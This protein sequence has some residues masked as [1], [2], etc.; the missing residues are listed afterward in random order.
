MNARNPLLWTCIIATGST[1]AHADIFTWLNGSGVWENPAMWNGPV[2]QYPDSILDTA[3]ISGNLTSATLNQNLALGTLNVLNGASVYSNGNS[4]FVNADT[5]LIG[6]GSALSVTPSPSLRDFDT[7]TLT[8]SQAILAMYGGLAQFDE[9]LIINNNGGVLGVGTIEMNSTTGHLVLN[10]GALWAT[11]GSGPSDTFLITRTDSSTSKLDWTSPD[12][13]IIVWDG[14][15]MINELPY[16]GSLGG[17]IQVSNYDDGETTF[18]SINGFIAAA[19]SELVFSGDNP[20]TPNRLVAPFIDSYGEV[21]S[22]GGKGII[23]SPIVALRGNIELASSTNLTIDAPLLIFNSID[24]NDDGS[25]NIVQFTANPEGTINFTGGASSIVMGA[26]SRFDLD[27]TGANTV[28]IADGSSVWLEAEYLDFG[29][30]S[31]F[32]GTLNIDGSLHLEPVNGNNFLSNNGEINLDSGQITG[33]GIFNTGLVRGTGSISGYTVNN[34][35]IIADAG[36]LQFGTVVMDGNSGTGILRAQ[37][38][39]LVMN[40][41]ANGSDQ[42]FTGQILVGNGIGVR[43]VLNAN[44]NLWVRDTNGQRGSIELNS[45]FVVLNDFG[46]NADM[47]VDGVS[48]LRVTGNNAEDRITFGSGSITTINGTLEAD[49]NTW[50][51]PGAQVNGSGTIDIVSTNKGI[52]FQDGATLG[53]V[54]LISSGAISLLDFFEAHASVHELTM[55]PTASLNMSMW[56]SGLQDEIITDLLTVQDHAILDGDLV[57]TNYPETDLPSGRTVTILEAASIEGGFDS[58]DFS[59]LGPN[60]RAFVTITETTVEVFVTCFA[61]LNADGQLN[62]FDASEFLTRYGQQDPLADLNADGQ[63]NFF[64]VAAFLS[65][66]DLGC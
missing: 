41:Q 26:G 18:E 51:V 27:G 63:F 55:R 43:E 1:T 64:D 53:N 47:V 56:Y 40:M 19:S 59:G 48:L 30:E 57:L 61:D 8:I 2:G 9:A 29:T 54:S 58:I 15:T 60:R 52:F 36:T 50:F 21:R 34:A 42:N 28:N 3:T 25:A 22:T 4:I 37:T 32:D 44:V 38:G 10:D 31:P 24:V 6:I 12:A 35:E 13:S 66:Y 11:D 46:T 33:R 45:G 17:K 49:G 23:E 62:F 65:A 39:D 5:Q 16:T 7:D 14:K 20:V